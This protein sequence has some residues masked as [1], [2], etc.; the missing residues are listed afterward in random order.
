MKINIST[1]QY[2]FAQTSEDVVDGGEIDRVTIYGDYD[3]ATGFCPIAI[4]MNIYT[5]FVG[6][7]NLIVDGSIVQ[8]QSFSIPTNEDFLIPANHTF[9]GQTI[10][11][12]PTTG[13][14][15]LRINAHYIMIGGGSAVPLPGLRREITIN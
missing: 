14:V 13:N 12:L 2:C 1:G 5:F 4:T 8:S 15:E 10:M 6:S 3:S 11:Q 9:I 7:A